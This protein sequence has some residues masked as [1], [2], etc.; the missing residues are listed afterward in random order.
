MARSWSRDRVPTMDA[1][2]TTITC[3]EVSPPASRRSARSWVREELGMPV[4]RLEVG[5]RPGGHSRADDP[6]AGLLPADPGGAE[7]GGLARPGLADHQ[8]VAVARGEE[9][10]DPVGLLDVQMS[11][12]TQHLFGECCGPTCPVPSPILAT[13]DSVMRCSAAR[14]SVVV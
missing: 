8:V 11:M 9:R 12:K 7:H 10:P 4:P 14:S 1:S 13:A 3:R 5:G 6:E 2:S